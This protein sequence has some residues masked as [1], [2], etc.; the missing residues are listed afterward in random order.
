MVFVRLGGTKLWAEGSST[1]QSCWHVRRL[2][3]ELR[4]E[5]KNM[6]RKS[7]TAPPDQTEAMSNEQKIHTLL[8]M[9]LDNDTILFNMTRIRRNIEAI[10]RADERSVLAAK[11]LVDPVPSYNALF[12]QRLMEQIRKCKHRYLMENEEIS[13]S[14]SLSVDDGSARQVGDIPLVDI[15][16]FSLGVKGVDEV[17]GT[18]PING[19]TGMPRGACL[20]FGAPKGAGKT[21]LTVQIA[22]AVGHPDYPADK[23]AELDGVLYIQNE[24]KVEIFRT[25]AARAWSDSHNILISSSNNLR[26]HIALVNKH[27]PRL[28]IVDSLQ[29]TKQAKFPSGLQMILGDYK[30]LASSMGT[31][32]WIISHVNS[33]GTL[34]GGTYAGHKVDIEMIARRNKYDKSEFLIACDE[35]NRYGAT[36]KRA[37]FRHVPEGIASVTG[38]GDLTRFGYKEEE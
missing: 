5:R 14:D 24:E 23:E 34:K 1:L 7:T 21:R 31:S 3:E 17:L 9:G 37:V 20:V 18:D 13:H 33:K 16:R 35:K 27:R 32:F 30:S 26:Q 36:G 38:V 28:V 11:F 12:R 19:M 4:T 15:P 6:A 10:E 2:L 8:H 25:R 29:D 22:A